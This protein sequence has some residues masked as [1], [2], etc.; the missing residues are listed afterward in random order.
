MFLSPTHGSPAF[1]DKGSQPLLWAFFRPD[2][3]HL[4]YK[5]FDNCYNLYVIYKCDRSPHNP[6]AARGPRF[7]DPC[8]KI[9]IS[10]QIPS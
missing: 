6:T 7:T 5:F 4:V 8:F 1:Y 2:M 9:S 10:I 3:E